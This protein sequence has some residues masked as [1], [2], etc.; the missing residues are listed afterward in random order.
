MKA[1]R[2]LIAAALL[3]LALTACSNTEEAAPE[4]MESVTPIENS[5]PQEEPDDGTN[6]RGNIE[7]TVGEEIS[8]T[9]YDSDEEVYKLK[10]TGIEPAF[11]C[12]EP[13]AQPAENGNFVKVDLEA[14][15]SSKEALDNSYYSSGIHI[16]SGSFKYIDNNGTTF[17]GYL[18][19]GSSF[20]CNPSSENFPD[21]LGPAQKSA[22]SV[23][24]DV[25]N[26]DGVIVY[27]DQLANVSVEYAI[28]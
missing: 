26:L 24:L 11:Q 9:G 1:P 20:S 10:V 28:Q 3:P 15:T 2:L 21:S 14:Q 18:S 8:V 22:G 4:P 7:A 16:S 12:T 25:P 13:Y 5:T 23:I 6:E 19:T 27:E 17:G